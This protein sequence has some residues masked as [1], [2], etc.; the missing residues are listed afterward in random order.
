VITVER[1]APLLTVQDSGRFG[2]LASGVTHS[3]PL[4]GLA[5]A[6][7]NT[8]VGNAAGAAALEGCLGGAQFRC[9]RDLTFAITGAD[10][11]VM[12]NGSGVRTYI[13]QRAKTGD[14]ITIDQSMRGAVW[15]VALRG[16]IDVP[17][18]LGSRSTLLAA[19]LGGV[20]GGP[21]KAGARLRIGDEM[22][23]DPVL[24]DVPYELRA[25]LDDASIPLAPAPRSDALD[26]AEWDR[27]YRRTFTISRSVSRVGYRLE[28]DPLPCRLPADIPSEPA[29]AGAMQLPPQ[30]HPIVLMADFPT[31][32][33]YPVIGVVPLFALGR[34]AQRA[35]GSPT[36]FTAI[37]IDEALN[38]AQRQRDALSQW[39][40]HG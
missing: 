40:N 24:R 13:T 8:L 21:I 6:V 30:G 4:D 9:E 33:G 2:Y 31:I 23:R 3:G 18:V 34:F 17:L 10:V 35:P 5:L 27:F 12:C 39:S 1:P 20:D 26:S 36:R 19:G 7:A 22:A 32:G 25:P 15:Y 11:T 37:T 29:C 38:A 14:T 28:G 16:G